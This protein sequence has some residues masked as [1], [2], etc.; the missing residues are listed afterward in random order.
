MSFDLFAQ[1]FA[2]G[3]AAPVRVPEILDVLRPFL[4]VGPEDGGF[5]STHTADGGE[6]DSISAMASAGSW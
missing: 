1:L 5:C 3:R 6:A 4:V 2:D